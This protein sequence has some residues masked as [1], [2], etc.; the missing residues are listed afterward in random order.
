MG[1]A[2]KVDRALP[3]V[4]PS[5]ERVVTQHEPHASDNDLRIRL[6]ALPSA[7]LVDSGIVVVADQQMLLATQTGK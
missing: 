1:V 5:S 6:D 7:T 4:S 3:H 2:M